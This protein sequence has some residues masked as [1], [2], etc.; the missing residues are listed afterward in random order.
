MGTK[1]SERLLT[2]EQKTAAQAREIAELKETVRTLK[3]GQ[4]SL[5]KTCQGLATE[6]RNFTQGRSYAI[7]DL[8]R[9]LADVQKKNSDMTRTLESRHIYPPPPEPP[10]DPNQDYLDRQRE[11]EDR[12]EERYN[13]FHGQ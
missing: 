7:E 13:R 3:G 1:N 4:E 12:R 9:Q 2:L 8:Q 5:L 11:E 10:R 6:L